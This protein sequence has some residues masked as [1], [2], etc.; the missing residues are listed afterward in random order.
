M[1]P[2]RTMGPTG[3][4]IA[5][6]LLLGLALAGCGGGGDLPAGTA[7]PAVVTAVVGGGNHT[8]AL[9]SD[10]TVWTWGYNYSGQ[11][12]D[13]TVG[14]DRRTPAE[15]PGLT[16][17]SALEAGG[18]HTLALAGDGSAWAWGLNSS[19]QLGEGNFTDRPFPV[20]VYGYHW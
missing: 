12:G 11:L 17:I 1:T 18:L 10:G 14:T 5:L 20:E 19:G 15:V 3:R 13:G 16:G 4:L 7:G 8:A 2:S 9:K 6:V